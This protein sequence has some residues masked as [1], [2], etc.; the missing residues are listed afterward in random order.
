MKLKDI[1]TQALIIA[2]LI[3]LL[4]TGANFGDALAL[5]ALVSLL[6]YEKFL[7]SKRVADPSKEI[8]DKIAAVEAKIDNGLNKVNAFMAF[9]GGK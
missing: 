2:F 6:G 9:R 5:S 8:K 3:R 1:P 7:E 4:I